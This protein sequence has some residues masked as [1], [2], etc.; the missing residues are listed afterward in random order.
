MLVKVGFVLLLAWLVGVLGL[1]EAGDLVHVLLLIGLMLLLLGVLKAR[2]AAATERHIV[3]KL[4][5]K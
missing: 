1:F 5:D 2:D 4:P 3:A